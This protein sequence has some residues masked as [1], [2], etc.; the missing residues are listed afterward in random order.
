MIS[1]ETKNRR[2][3]NVRKKPL[4]YR[5]ALH[6]YAQRNGEVYLRDFLSN[7]KWVKPPKIQNNKENFYV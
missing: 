4:A 2:A 6:R 7:E 5:N 1:F 3:G